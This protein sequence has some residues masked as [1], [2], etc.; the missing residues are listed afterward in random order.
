MTASSDP[1]ARLEVLIQV[2]VQLQDGGHVATPAQRS[3]QGAV[4]DFG[5]GPVTAAG[6]REAVRT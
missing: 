1:R 4:W 5:C 2:L 3:F 6:D